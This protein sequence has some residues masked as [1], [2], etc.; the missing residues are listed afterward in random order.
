MKIDAMVV[1]KRAPKWAC[2]KPINIGDKVLV[3]VREKP[4]LIYPRWWHRVGERIN[5][6]WLMRLKGLN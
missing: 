4:N 3:L 1:C 2:G 6:R 5:W